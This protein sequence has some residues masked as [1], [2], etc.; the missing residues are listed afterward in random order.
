MPVLH[1][2]VELCP[3]Y[4][5]GNYSAVPASPSPYT[6]HVFV[7]PFNLPTAGVSFVVWRMCWT[8][9]AGAPG[10]EKGVVRLFKRSPDASA[11]KITIGEVKSSE[12]LNPGAS[13]V[14]NDARDITSEFQKMI[15]DRQ[16]GHIGW[17]ITGDGSLLKFWTSRLEI[18]WLV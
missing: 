9:P 14:S 11:P 8:S 12:M 7:T 5:E 13:A 17:D 15:L 6:S 4:F 18:G 16:Y 10:A 1:S 2:V 3:N